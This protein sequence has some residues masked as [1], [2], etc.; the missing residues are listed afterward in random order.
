MV[1]VVTSGSG[2]APSA[3]PCCRA[4]HGRAFFASVVVYPSALR[5]R[6]ADI[7]GA[8]SGA[9]RD[10]AR[11]SN[12][13]SSAREHWVTPHAVTDEASFRKPISVRLGTYAGHLGGLGGRQQPGRGLGCLPVGKQLGHAVRDGLC[14][15]VCKCDGQIRVSGRSSAHDTAAPA[16]FGTRDCTRF[17][18][19][20]A[21]EPRR[22]GALFPV[23][24]F[25]ELSL[26][27]QIV[28]GHVSVL[29]GINATAAHAGSHGVAS[30]S[31]EAAVIASRNSAGRS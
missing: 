24:S 31:S 4:R 17:V 8:P 23:D 18:T 16:R 30:A 25:R 12:A 6:R 9:V 5:R 20:R 19:S 3:A 21:Q 2:A 26:S 27:R 22:D 11:P 13:A 7:C 28:R 10:D 29:I 14:L 1:G 15:I